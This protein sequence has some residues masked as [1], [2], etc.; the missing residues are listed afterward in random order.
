MEI[1]FDISLSKSQQEA[2]DLIHDNKYKYYTFAWSRQSGKSVLMQVLC[3]E[4]LTEYNR[5]IAYVC[6]NYLLAKKIYRELTRILPDSFIKTKN[7]SDFFI[8]SIFGSTLTLYSA[9]SGASLRGNTF[10]YLILDEFAFFQFEQT[11]GTNLWFDILSPTLKAK[12]KKCIFVSTPLGKNNLFYDMYLRGLSNEYPNYISL[13]KNIYDDGFITQEEIDEIEHTI[14]SMSFQQEYLCEFLDS[15]LTF[16]KGFEECF[17]DFK[18]NPKEK[19]WAGLD[20]SSNGEDETI[21]TFINQS[22]QV[23]QFKVEGSLD[24]K[25]KQIA[26]AINHIPTLQYIYMEN[27]GVGS[28]MINEIKKLIVR[29]HCIVEFTTTNSSKEEI[30]SRL[31]VDISKKDIHFNNEDGELYKQLGTFVASYSKSGKMT[32]AGKSGTHDDRIMSLALANECQAK[33]QYAVNQNVK[34]ARVKDLNIR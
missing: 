2:Y 27:N 25:Y 9:E 22:R 31:A 24:Y 21:L 15:S 17:S 12:G 8:E 11:D 18:F 1:R 13:K 34:F 20:L 33:T 29:K 32:F 26:E 7:G 4:W 19:A 10:D 5:N 23:L 14:P 16:F 30:V 6:K 3:I 28:P